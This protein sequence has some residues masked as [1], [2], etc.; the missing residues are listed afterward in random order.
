M[1]ATICGISHLTA[2]KS[3][4]CEVTWTIM[5]FDG[6]W[7][8]VWFIVDVDNVSTINM[9]LVSHMKGWKD[10]KFKWSW[11]GLFIYLLRCFSFFKDC[12]CTQVREVYL[13]WL[14]QLHTASTVEQ[15]YFGPIISFFLSIFISSIIII[16]LLGTT[17][18]LK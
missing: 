15:K 8:F 14:T 11:I 9:H 3:A 12:F 4:M 1:S 7:K 17:S 18:L 6:K 5:F 16:L 13:K 2:P 10:R